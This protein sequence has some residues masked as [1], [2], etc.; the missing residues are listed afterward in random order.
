MQ[1]FCAET[2]IPDATSLAAT[3]TLATCNVGDGFLRARRKKQPHSHTHKIILRYDFPS[4][5]TTRKE[6]QEAAAQ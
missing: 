3:P 4:N 2:F 6:G 1:P 5:P